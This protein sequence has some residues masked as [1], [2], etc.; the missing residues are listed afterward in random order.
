MTPG[1]GKAK[2]T[3]AAALLSAAAL[4]GCGIAG[5]LDTDA[6]PQTSQSPGVAVVAPPPAL[7]PRPLSPPREVP[8]PPVPT[9]RG[10][11]APVTPTPA[12]SPTPTATPAPQPTPS[13][14]TTPT[15][16]PQP[17][18]LVA[19]LPRA[20]ALPP[21]TWTGAHGEQTAPWS[22][23]AP[24]AVV[25]AAT[26]ITHVAAARSA[27]EACGGIADRV[28]GPALDA[29]AASF[30]ADPAPGSPFDVVLLRFSTPAGADDALAALQSLGTECAG[31]ETADG[32]LGADAGGSVTLVSG[33][34]TL[35]VEA[36]VSDVLLVA[37][38]HEGAP[39]EAV[40]ALFAAV[41]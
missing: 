7:E 18:D 39:I 40:A 10:P 38:L 29:A 20:A 17:T 3:A 5:P 13:A 36:R 37:V 30:A 28:S 24:G 23:L 16:T 41:G 11:A 21:L 27:G 33:E 19:L 8:L 25:P 26:A 35:T 14:T 12:V 32:V 22:E 9:V 31:V 1:A 15:Q 2:A 6:P 4:A 34:A